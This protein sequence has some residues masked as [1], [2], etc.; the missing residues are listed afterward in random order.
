MV[1]VPSCFSFDM[2]LA[3]EKAQVV[4]LIN[5]RENTPPGI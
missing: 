1:Q 5:G 4:N 3:T 2:L